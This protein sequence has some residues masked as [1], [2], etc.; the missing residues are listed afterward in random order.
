VILFH[1]CFLGVVSNCL[2]WLPIFVSLCLSWQAWRWT[3]QLVVSLLQVSGETA[4]A[5]G[6]HCRLARDAMEFVGLI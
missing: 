6:M 1:V 4:L 2:S 3:M 5:S